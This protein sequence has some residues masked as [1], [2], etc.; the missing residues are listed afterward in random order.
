MQSE[1]PRCKKKK[2][3]RKKTK[4]H[5]SFKARAVERGRWA[6]FHFLSSLSAILLP[7][8]DLLRVL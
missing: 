5:L 1:Q 7:P 2:I 6:D 4:S 3:E 8:F